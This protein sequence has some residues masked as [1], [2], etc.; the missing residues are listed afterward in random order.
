MAAIA[1]FT[2]RE[3]L[4]AGIAHAVDDRH[5]V[6]A[7][8]ADRFPDL[9]HADA[10]SLRALDAAILDL[11]PDAPDTACFRPDTGY[12]PLIAWYRVRSLEPA[13]IALRNGFKG[14]T[15]DANSLAETR[16]CIESVLDG[17]VW[18]P[19]DVAQAALVNRPQRLTPREG[20]LARLIAHGLSN[21]EIAYRLNIATG[22]VKVYLSRLFDKLNVSDR[23]ELALLMLKHTGFLGVE[24]P[25]PSLRPAPRIEIFMH[26]S[27]QGFGHPNGF[28]GGRV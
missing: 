8:P 2:D 6:T 13:L 3:V 19:A 17:N 18:V 25:E 23:Y 10:P 4:T 20:Q 21:K 24:P 12:V 11:P 26:E 16:D 22:T 15:F 5:Q 7:Y 14:V 28:A 27:S 9:I 1:L